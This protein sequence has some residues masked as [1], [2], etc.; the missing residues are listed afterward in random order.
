MRV[1]DIVFV[2]VAVET[3]DTA[4]IDDK[5]GTQRNGVGP[6]SGSLEVGEPSEASLL[7]VSTIVVVASIEIVVEVV[8]QV[9]CTAGG[10][11]RRWWSG[12]ER[13]KQMSKPNTARDDS[14]FMSV[15]TFEPER[16]GRKGSRPRFY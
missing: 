8:T 14:F 10:T 15:T 2:T 4:E 1:P 7:A 13:A 16:L 6:V 3:D 9:I 12:I 11:W 5:D